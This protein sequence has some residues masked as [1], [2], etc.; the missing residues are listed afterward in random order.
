MLCFPLMTDQITNRRLVVD[1]WRVGLNLCDKKPLTRS[2][3]AEKISRLMS[4]KSADELREET[5]KVRLI[6]ESA[7]ARD[8]SSEKNMHKFISDLKAKV[9]SKRI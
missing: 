9:I 2:E 1:D 6:L 4:G 7:L 8:G 3:V 5:K